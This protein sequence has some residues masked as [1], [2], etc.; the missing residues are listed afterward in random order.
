M[1]DKVEAYK[2][3]FNTFDEINPDQDFERLLYLWDTMTDR[4]QTEIT[5]W[6]K[7]TSL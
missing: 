4:E 6:L 3:I 1:M 5:F 2:Q 7:S